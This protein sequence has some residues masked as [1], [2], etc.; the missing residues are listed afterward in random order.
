MGK[1]LYGSH[2]QLN[3]PSKAKE[4]T[5]ALSHLGDLSVP[6]LSLPG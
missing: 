5:S 6:F 4:S 3:P 1:H 2:S